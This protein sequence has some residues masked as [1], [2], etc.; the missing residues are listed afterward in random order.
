M[1]VGIRRDVAEIPVTEAG[2]DL[3]KKVLAR[4]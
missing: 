3:K 4:D 2:F 1:T